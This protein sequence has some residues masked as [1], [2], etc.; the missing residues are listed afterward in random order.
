MNRTIDEY[1]ESFCRSMHA[2]KRKHEEIVEGHRLADSLHARRELDIQMSYIE[3]QNSRIEKL[4]KD[5]EHRGNL[6]HKNF[7]KILSF[8]FLFLPL[9]CQNSQA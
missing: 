5:L 8:N 6:S 4:K 1:T 3:H 7:K 2:L 9:S